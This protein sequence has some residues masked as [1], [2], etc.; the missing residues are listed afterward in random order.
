MKRIFVALPLAASFL[1]TA[2]YNL[3]HPLSENNPKSLSFQR[4]AP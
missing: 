2:A 1:L 4:N 3:P